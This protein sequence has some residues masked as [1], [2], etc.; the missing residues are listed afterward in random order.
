MTSLHFY[1]IEVGNIAL[2][3]RNKEKEISSEEK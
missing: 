1:Y 2:A 3:E